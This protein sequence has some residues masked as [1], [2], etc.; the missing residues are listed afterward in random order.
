MRRE[1]PLQG[2]ELGLAGPGRHRLVVASQE[3]EGRVGGGDGEAQS[4]GAEQEAAPVATALGKDS[5]KNVEIEVPTQDSPPFSHPFWLS[6]SK[7][8][9]PASWPSVR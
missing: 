6:I 4:E 3:P 9:E 8:A 7:R 5:A 1:L 2:L